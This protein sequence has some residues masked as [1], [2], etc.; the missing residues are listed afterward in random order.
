MPDEC[1]LCEQPRRRGSYLYK[2]SIH[3]G[4]FKRSLRFCGNCRAKMVRWILD[5]I[6]RD[7]THQV[8]E[9]VVEKIEKVPDIRW[10]ADLQPDKRPWA[11]WLWGAASGA[12]GSAVILFLMGKF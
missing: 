4:T 1:D 11:L 2:F 12:F 9:K 5:G 6:E 7:C 3:T 8:H 10:R